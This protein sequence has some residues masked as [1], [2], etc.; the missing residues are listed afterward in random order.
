MRCP[1]HAH[2]AGNETAPAGEASPAGEIF[3]EE[4]VPGGNGDQQGQ[5]K[6]G[7]VL[8]AC[9]ATVL[10]AGGPRRG[11]GCVCVGGGGSAAG[12]AVVWLWCLES[13]HPGAQN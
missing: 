3:V 8:V 1:V 13:Q 4:V 7:D 10:K 6:P 5:I 2:P 11:S 12:W 9:S